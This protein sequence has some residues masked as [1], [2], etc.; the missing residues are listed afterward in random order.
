MIA[1]S[2]HESLEEPPNIP[3]FGG[4]ITKKTRRSCIED[5]IS[6]AANALQS[7]PKSPDPDPVPVRGDPMLPSPGQVLELRMKN[8]EQLQYLQSLR[9]DN[10][11]SDD[12]YKNKPYYLPLGGCDQ[13]NC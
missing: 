13:F 11:L 4:S 3:A 1:S 8:M 2:Q 7:N 6:G 5:T 12:E 9:N 10:I